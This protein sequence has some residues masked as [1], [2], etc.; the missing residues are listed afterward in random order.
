[1]SRVLIVEDTPSFRQW[2]LRA[3]AR[4]AP[5]CTAEGVADAATARMRVSAATPDLIVLDLGL[6]RKGGGVAADPMVGLELL[7]A[8]RAEAV[9]SRVVVVSS[10]TELADHCL[11]AGADDFIAK[12]S[13][14]LSSA[15]AAELQSPDV[16]GASR[17]V[18]HAEAE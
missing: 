4:L 16:R 12:N 11:R 2:L 17:C 14:E 9:R 10:H 3:V 6:P 1:M 13:G 18:P 8:W 5:E 7:Q 15:L